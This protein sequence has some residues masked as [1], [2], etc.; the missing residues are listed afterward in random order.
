M[1]FESGNNNEPLVRVGNEGRER[2]EG[3]EDV[4]LAGKEMI[5]A[6]FFPADKIVLSAEERQEAGVLL[7]TL[8]KVNPDLLTSC[9]G[10]TIE[11]ARDIL[12]PHIK[13]L[14]EQEN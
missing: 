14:Q 12:A 7:H 13:A 2:T 8:A 3:P 4:R 9:A 1:T 5:V 6:A 11:E 10:K